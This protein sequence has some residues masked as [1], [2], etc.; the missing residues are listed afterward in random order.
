[1]EVREAFYQAGAERVLSR[2]GSF[3]ASVQC[4]VRRSLRAAGYS[5]ATHP[6]VTAS[7]LAEM[8]DVVRS[9]CEDEDESVVSGG[10]HTGVDDLA[11]TEAPSASAPITQLLSMLG[12]QRFDGGG[13]V[14]DV[15]AA[16]ERGESDR[17]RSTKKRKEERRRRQR[18]EAEAEAAS[19]LGDL[20]P[21][22]SPAAA[23]AQA[24]AVEL[25]DVMGSPNFCAAMF[26]AVDAAFAVVTEKGAAAAASTTG[27]GAGSGSGVCSPPHGLIATSVVLPVLKKQAAAKRKVRSRNSAT[28][29]A[30]SSSSGGG[31]G[32][33]G[34]DEL[35]MDPSTSTVPIP[36]ALM[37]L[38]KMAD[39][40]ARGG[41]DE[42]AAPGD[43]VALAALADVNKD[44]GSGG[45]VLA[46]VLRQAMLSALVFQIASNYEVGFV[47]RFAFC[48]WLLAGL[49]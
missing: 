12:M 20:L 3:N 22:Q 42:A 16:E 36:N 34:D 40:I 25:L 45:V 9:A 46:A 37:N 4:A 27:S 7:D 39:D 1:M 6:Y 13:G 26:D 28:K 31:G 17:N 19:F 33:G 8:L 18:E 23:Q 29:D 32:G 14:D 10:V 2:L 11:E 24:L 30:V 49:C 48:V 21:E 43:A 35:E 15:G 5:V 44:T 47:L 41:A 38:S